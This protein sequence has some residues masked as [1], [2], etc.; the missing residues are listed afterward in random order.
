MA[1]LLIGYALAIAIVF[2]A[3][4]PISTNRPRGHH[5]TDA[6][7]VGMPYSHTAF[8]LG[9]GDEQMSRS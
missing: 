7:L 6:G 9:H 4:R 1:A 8:L 5:P 2:L 3:S